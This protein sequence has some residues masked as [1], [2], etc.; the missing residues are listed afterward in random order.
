M[1]QIQHNIIAGIIFI[2]L[3]KIVFHLILKH[4]PVTQKNIKE[5]LDIYK[6]LF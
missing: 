5:W 2:I 4:H 3:Y 6:D 1:T